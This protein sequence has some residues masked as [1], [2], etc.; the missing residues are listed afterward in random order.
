MKY[1]GR[2]CHSIDH[3]NLNPKSSDRRP[4]SLWQTRPCNTHR[5]PVPG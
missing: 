4:R 1:S 2:N 5:L 3:R